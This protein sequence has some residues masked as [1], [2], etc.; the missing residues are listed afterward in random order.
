MS[1]RTSSRSTLTI[2][3]S[4][5]S[6]SLKYLIVASMAAR[7]SSSEP[8]SLTATC[9]ASERVG[10]LV[11]RE[12]VPRGGQMS[13]GRARKPVS[14]SRIEDSERETAPSETQADFWRISQGTASGVSPSNRECHTDRVQTDPH[15]SV[16]RDHAPQ[17]VRAE[18]RPVDEHD[19]LRANRADWD[20]YADEYQATH[21]EFLGD[22]GFL[23]G[24]ECVREDDLGALGDVAGRRVLELGCGAGQ[25]SRWVLAHGGRPVGLDV[26][27]RQLQHSRRI[28]DHL[29]TVVPTVCAGA[30]A[31]P[32][33]DGAFD[34]VF[35]AFG[36]L[37]FIADAEAL[38]KEMARVTRP[39]GRLA[40]SVTH[41]TRW[42]FPDDPG[43]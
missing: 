34:I 19:S 16:P 9:G 8:M 4:T 23:W 6:P 24:P 14:P 29:G 37:Q 33:P 41:P 5:M 26:S 10:V 18:R 2:V 11:I 1:S 31:L 22:A 3:P 15:A 36:A 32:F 27:L 7:K 20:R 25:C 42:M 17:T 13:C 12:L 40:F 28:D 43:E 21:G 30:A 38:A 39:A 35:S